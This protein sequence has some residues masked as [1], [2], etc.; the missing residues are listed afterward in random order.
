MTDTDAAAAPS[1]PAE[2]EALKGAEALHEDAT[3]AVESFVPSEIAPSATDHKRKLGDLEPHEDEEAPP[4]KQEVAIDAPA[5]V[6]DESGPEAKEIAAGAGE[7]EPALPEGEIDGSGMLTSEIPAAAFDKAKSDDMLATEPKPEEIDAEQLLPDEGTGGLA[8]DRGYEVQK[9]EAPPMNGQLASAQN[10]QQV[11]SENL[12]KSTPEVS[13][14]SSLPSAGQQPLVDLAASSDKIEV[15][16]SKVGVLIGKAGDTIKYLQINSGAK[17]QITRDAEADPHSTTRPVELI[18]TVENINKAKQLIKDVI[19]EADAGGSPS[20]VARGFSTVQS[21]GEQTEIKVPN[22]KVG[23]II[24]K[25]GETIKNLQTRSGARIQLIP[26]HLPE[27]DSS[28]ERTVRI[29]GNKKQIES[30][31]E[32]IKEVMNQDSMLA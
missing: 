25:G 10:V 27:G 32:M 13:Q 4:K 16:N 2:E 28:K 18:G 14:Q 30:A 15:P 17:I 5:V 1:V 11:P 7:A 24:G 31:K 8:A 26:Q 22:E 9:P 21:G 3:A 20:L 23:L 6:A 12:E 29:T 19:A